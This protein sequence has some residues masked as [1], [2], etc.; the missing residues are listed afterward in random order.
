MRQPNAHYHVLGF[1]AF[2]HF[3]AGKHVE[4]ASYYQRLREASPEY[5]ADDHIAARPLY[6]ES[7]ISEARSIFAKLARL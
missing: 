7:E 5:D 1:A 6:L 4:A 3:R 2:C